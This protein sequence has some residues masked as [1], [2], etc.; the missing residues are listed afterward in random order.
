MTHQT[1]TNPEQARKTLLSVLDTL[2]DSYFESDRT[3]VITYANLAFCERL[4]LS[5][6]EVIGK[7]FRHFTIRETIRE[8]YQKFQQVIDTKT[9]LE[10]FKYIYRP[11]DG[12]VYIAE[13][14]VSPII[15]NGEVIGTRG[16]M[17]DITDKVLA[18]EALRQTKE[19][20]EARAEQ[21]AAINR[22][23]MIVNQSLNLNDNL[24]A[25]CQEL[26][27]I[28]P[29]RNAGIGLLGADNTS[30]KIVAFHAIDP[31]EESALGMVLPFEGNPSSQEVIEKKQTVVVQDAQSDP[32]MSPLADISKSRGTKSI[33][34]VPL[35][36]RCFHNK[37]GSNLVCQ[38]AYCFF[39]IFN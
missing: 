34:I 10:P 31:E 15:E 22:I 33:M 4:G 20:A 6:E 24:Q 21:L 28:F 30:L 13:T 39:D 9:P 18:E 8:I 1:E 23:S 29:I 19:E 7:H 27:N 36:T 14:T 11:Q 5:R 38:V 32:R 3:G 16:V 12:H 37:N 35:L 17:R 2:P 26:T 25:L